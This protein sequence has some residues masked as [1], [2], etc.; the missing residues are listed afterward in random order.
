MP[1]VESF[2][3]NPDSTLHQYGRILDWYRNFQPLDIQTGRKYVRLLAAQVKNTLWTNTQFYVL[4]LCYHSV[5]KIYD[6][7]KMPCAFWDSTQSACIFEILFSTGH[8]VGVSWKWY[9]LCK[10][11]TN[12]KFQLQHAW[13]ENMPVSLCM[14]MLLLTI[15]FVSIAFGSFDHVAY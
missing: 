9:I 12:R 1:R 5:V 3:V 10:S 15:Y 13:F 4:V 6:Y 7:S 14:N 2:H 8:G 11:W